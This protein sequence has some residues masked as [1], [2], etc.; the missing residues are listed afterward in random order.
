MVVAVTGRAAV[1]AVGA[2]ATAGRA[3]VELSGKLPK[4]Q[5]TGPSGEP[6]RRPMSTAAGIRLQKA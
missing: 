1:A 3:A 4:L 6:P 2:V 5:S